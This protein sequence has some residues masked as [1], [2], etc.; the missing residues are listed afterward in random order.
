MKGKSLLLPECVLAEPR[1]LKLTIEE[2][3]SKPGLE[4]HVDEQLESGNNLGKG[5]EGGTWTAKRASQGSLLPSGAKLKG[6]WPQLQKVPRL[7]RHPGLPT[8]YQRSQRTLGMR[9]WICSLE[10]KLSLSLT[11]NSLEEG[12][13]VCKPVTHVCMASHHPLLPTMPDIDKNHFCL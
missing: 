8:C 7:R 2:R 9:A 13:L 10:A 5:P 1:A 3:P 6:K 12:L 11:H 4:G